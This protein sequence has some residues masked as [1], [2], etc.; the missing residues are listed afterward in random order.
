MSLSSHDRCI[1]IGN[2]TGTTFTGIKISPN[3]DIIWDSFT[4]TEQWRDVE[5]VNGRDLYF[6]IARTWVQIPVMASSHYECELLTY[7]GFL[8]F[9]PVR[10][11]TRCKPWNQNWFA[12]IRCAPS[13]SH[14]E[15]VCTMKTPGS[16]RLKHSFGCGGRNLC[17]TLSVYYVAAEFCY[18]SLFKTEVSLWDGVLLILTRSWCSALKAAMED[19]T[20]I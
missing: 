8:W 9:A 3:C 20:N 2:A 18:K 16:R 14:S 4:M 10:M 6:A 13:G 11:N 15:S 17:R 7:T 5:S 12:R 1:V 19:R